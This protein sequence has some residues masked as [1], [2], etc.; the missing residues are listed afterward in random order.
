MSDL[1]PPSQ[2]SPGPAPSSRRIAMR[3]SFE[4]VPQFKKFRQE[5]VIGPADGQT[6][7]DMSDACGGM[8]GDRAVPLHIAPGMLVFRIARRN[9]RAFAASCLIVAGSS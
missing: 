8:T 2:N 7:V 1:K 3:R 9:A 5:W 4:A 6:P